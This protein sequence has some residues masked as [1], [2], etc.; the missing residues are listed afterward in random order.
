MPLDAITFASCSTSVSLTLQ[1]TAFQSSHP[2]GGVR[3]TPLSSAAA[4]RGAVTTTAATS[5]AAITPART[6]PARRGNVQSSISPP[7][8]YFDDLAIYRPRVPDLH[9]TRGRCQAAILA[10]V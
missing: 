9:N 6:P 1:P 8:R 4:G 7:V 10:A 2:M 5:S 3:A